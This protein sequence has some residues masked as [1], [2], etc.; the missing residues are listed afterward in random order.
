MNEHSENPRGSMEGLLASGYVGTVA[1]FLKVC[2]APHFE[3]R[4]VLKGV[5]K[6]SFPI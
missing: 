1:V 3:D 2:R 4:G 5:V 6:N